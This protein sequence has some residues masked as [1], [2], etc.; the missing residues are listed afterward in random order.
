PPWGDRMNTTLAIA[1]KEIK[2]YFASP[3]F[4]VVT[5]LF[6]LA[7]GLLFAFTIGGPNASADQTALLRNSFSILLFL[8][9]LLTPLL[10]MRLIAQEKQEGTIELLLT[11][12]VTDLQLVLGKYLA[13]LVMLAAMLATTLIQVLVLV[14]SAVDKHRFLFL[15]IGNIDT[16]TLLAGYL[17]M[18]L[19]L[20]GY[21]SIGLFASALTGNQIIAAFVGI[22]LL[23]VLLVIDAAASLAQPPLSDFFASVGPRSHA[24][25]FARGLITA[26]DVVYALSLIF[27]PIFLA[28]VI[29]GARKWR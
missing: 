27:V 17:G 26:P 20:G 25:N 6:I 7:T 1:R 12:P 11:Q 9:I 16:A 13:A 15:S 19:L 10:T 14:F 8:M 5:A 3:L 4:Y 22:V 28:T 29:L 24:D 21:M 23:L 2:V 18:I